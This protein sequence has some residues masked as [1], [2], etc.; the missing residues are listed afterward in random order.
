MHKN[1]AAFQDKFLINELTIYETDYWRWSLRPVQ[2][3]LGA[4]ILSLRRYSERLSDLNGPE[5]GD[6]A[7]IVGVVEDCLEKSFH[8]DKINYLMLMMV[9]PH[10]HFHVIPRYA[11]SRICAGKTWVDQ[12]WPSFP[13]MGGDAAS[14]EN[15]MEIKGVLQSTRQT[16]A[17]PGKA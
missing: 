4:G 15:L 11:A 17:S 12:G 5:G 9:D 7:A 6:F 2:C 8:Y 10:L 1:F 16:N 13:Q 14:Q 3:T